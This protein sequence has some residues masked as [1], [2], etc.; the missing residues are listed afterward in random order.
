LISLKKYLEM[1]PNGSPSVKTDAGQLLSVLL[2]RYRTALLQVGKYGYQACPACGSSMQQS[3]S[4]LEGRLA[5]EITISAVEE[6]GDEL[7]NQLS[8]W[9]KYTAEH[10][11]RKAEEVKDLLMVLAG[12][13]ESFGDRDQRYAAQLNNFAARLR[14]VAD[15]EDLS[16][17]RSSLMQAANDLKT[18]V[19][20]MER[21]SQ[22]AITQLQNRILTYES[23][24]KESE[25]LALRD[26]VTG[27]PNRLQ[28]ERAMELR[29][30]NHRCFCV[31]FLDLNQ[32]KSVNDR[33]GHAAGDFVLKQFAGELVFH[34]RPGDVVGRWGGDEF[35]ILLDCDLSAAMA[36]VSRMRQ[37][38]FGSYSVPDGGKAGSRKAHIQ[39][40]IGLA[41]WMAEETPEHLIERADHA[42]YEDKQGIKKERPEPIIGQEVHA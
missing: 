15:L 36:T 11:R 40:A 19:D 22:Q 42:M 33:F 29:I 27:L 17:V 1:D 14:T 9:A 31:A 23:K 37:W 32:F 34:L 10:L 18:H 4:T 13:A 3:L 8:Q 35:V 38:L 41:E 30:D 28:L 6:V 5:G 2:A 20:A 12:T 39:A 21:D 26:R 7:T 24:L 16:Q 25:D